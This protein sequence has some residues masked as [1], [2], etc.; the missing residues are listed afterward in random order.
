[1]GHFAGC[2]N[3]LLAAVMLASLA[4]A[5]STPDYGAQGIKALE[6]QKYD[7]AVAAFTKAVEAD[8]KDYYAHFHLGLAYSMVNRDA[9]GIA[10]YRKALEI[11]PGLYE[12]ELNAGILLLGQKQAGEAATLL[13]K[14]VAQKPKEARPRYYLGEALLAIGDNAHAEEHLKI[15]V[16]L[17]PKSPGAQLALAHAL[18]RQN[19]L[20]DAAPYFREAAR[21]DA[22]YRDALLELGQLYENA[23]RNT[24]AIQIYRQFPENAAAQERM[25]A[26]LL[27]T[28][29]YAEAVPELEA[30]YA[31]QPTTANRTALAAAYLFTN[32]TDQALP[33]LDKSVAE[34]PASYDLR[35]MYGRALRDRKQ[36]PAAARQF[37]EALKLK[38]DSREAWN[39][40]AGML[41]LAGA[42]PQALAAFDR[43]RQL[44]E[45]SPANWYFRAI[46]Q[47]KLKDYKPALESYARFLS[48][49]QGKF[50]DE[51]FKA[52]QRMR[53]IQKELSKH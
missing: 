47:D 23:K 19:R 33:L 53:V 37:A 28:K 24:E 8:P 44:G 17:S 48:L 43:A 18:A 42:L 50:A 52:R 20:D 46:I 13:E 10:A 29:K 32:K 3:G 38:G 5:Q 14:A 45:D 34:E 15:A 30:A 36:Y 51:E 31:R 39:E 26:L 16:E 12:A 25:G 7:A 9:E 21:L 41:Y 2:G 1:M 4:A 11:K 22:S 49:S 27:E 40:F 35:M 6:E